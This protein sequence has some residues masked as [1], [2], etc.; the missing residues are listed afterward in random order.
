M[1]LLLLLL[2]VIFL[3]NISVVIQSNVIAIIYIIVFTINVFIFLTKPAWSVHLILM[4]GLQIT[5]LCKTMY[6]KIIFYLPVRYSYHIIF[7]T[8]LIR[9]FDINT[10]IINMR[11]KEIKYD[12]SYSAFIHIIFNNLVLYFITK[13]FVYFGRN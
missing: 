10:F 13:N 3:V 5:I 7:V 4:N 8:L 1:L 2:L 12:K 11:I 9:E 6:F